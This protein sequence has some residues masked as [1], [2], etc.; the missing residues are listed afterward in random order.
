MTYPHILYFLVP[1][2]HSVFSTSVNIFQTKKELMFFIADCELD[3]KDFNIV[4][5]KV[6]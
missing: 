5:Y 4:K 1:E 3:I 6:D 2:G